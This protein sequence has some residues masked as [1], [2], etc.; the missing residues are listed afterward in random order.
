MSPY[1]WIAIAG[2]IITGGDLIF[3]YYWQHPS[4][5]IYGVGMLTYI[6]GLNFLVQSYKY[7]NIAIASAALIV[8]NLVTLFLITTLV[9]GEK[10]SLLKIVGMVFAMIAVILLEY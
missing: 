5:W 7:Q 2:V 8:I 3:R 9:F 10:I 1:L 6:I 4:W